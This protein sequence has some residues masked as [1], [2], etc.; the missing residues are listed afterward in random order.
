MTAAGIEYPGLI[1]ISSNLWDSQND[2]L[3]HVIVHEVG[4]QWWY[5]MVGSNQV[6][7]PWLDEGL[8][9]YVSARYFGEQ[10]SLNYQEG[11]LNFYRGQV[12]D[13]LE[14]GGEVLPLALPA[15][16][17]T[18]GS[19]RALVYSS[20]A[21]LFAEMG[22]QEEVDAM[23]AAYYEAFR[24]QIATSADLQKIIEETLGPEAARV[25]SQQVF[26]DG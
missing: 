24:Y 9:E 5:S 22:P 12:A 8:T 1:F 15:E 25:Y 7:E 13:Y 18:G 23:L 3:E 2:I 26:G 17:F 6:D 20:G 10:Y 19:Y 14:E 4:H 16:R 21:V 11:V